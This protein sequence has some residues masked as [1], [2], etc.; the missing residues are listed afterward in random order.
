MQ[1]TLTTFHLLF[2]SI[3]EGLSKMGDLEKKCCDLPELHVNMMEGD[4]KK[5]CCDLP[6]FH[7]SIMEKILAWLP[8]DSVC[9]FRSVCQ[10][11]N[12]LLSSTK[13]ITNKWRKKP[14]NTDP[15]LVA[16]QIP[17]K[18]VKEPLNGGPGQ[19]AVQLPESGLASCFFNQTWKDTS[20]ISLSFLLDQC[21]E[22]NAEYPKE[23]EEIPSLFECYGS[24]AGLFL[25]SGTRRWF[26]LV[27]CNPLTRT[28][29]QLPRFS[30]DTILSVGIVGDSGDAYK[31]VLVG[32]LDPM[33]PLK[34]EIYDSI[35]K[36]WRIAGH[37]PEC[38][39]DLDMDMV[40]CDGYFYCSGM[41]PVG[42]AIVGYNIREGTS[43]L[44][45]LPEIADGQCMEPRLFTCGSRV[46]VAAHIV[47]D[48][49]E[50]FNVI[51]QVII[52]E[53]E[54]V[55]VN[56]SSSS[57]S[58]KEIAR[59]P[60][61]YLERFS[62]NRT[63]DW[64][65]CCIGLGDRACFIVYK[66]KKVKEMFVYSVTENTWSWLPNR[67]LDTTTSTWEG[68]ELPMAFEPRPDMKVG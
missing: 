12:A 34:V 42:R 59:M 26:A 57:S 46:L 51:L 60:P 38:V 5:K 24:A 50:L 45:P 67:P 47:A 29:L 16:V 4:L 37:L 31:V 53:L 61:P 40:F 48:D 25:V 62:M 21:P 19:V 35:D 49:L 28:S 52:W 63:L 44:R 54:K 17:I 41:I 27:V 11:W 33:D 56:S 32:M 65:R 15:W 7:I 6:E 2:C 64:T 9:R 23:T 20:S 3:E 68:S 22:E 8:V 36:S 43:I 14:L 18:W 10:E 58:W 13:F 30:S 39:E 1:W 55:K 66:G